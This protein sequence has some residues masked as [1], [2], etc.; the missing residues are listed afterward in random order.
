MYIWNQHEFV[1]NCLKWYKECDLEPGNP[2]DGLW[3]KAHY[4]APFCLGGEEWVWLL[5][6]HHA[7]QGVL[8]SLEF[9]HCCVGG[10]E[11]KYLVGEW[12]YLLSVFILFC[13]RR[14]RENFRNSH[15]KKDEFGRSL[16]GLKNAERMNSELDELGRSVNAVKGGILS[17]KNG[18]GALC[19]TIEQM[20]EDGKR[21]G[22]LSKERKLGI[23][24][25]GNA[26]KGGMKVCSQKWE[27]TVTGKITAAGPLTQWQRARG[28]DT[29]N[30][31]RRYD[32]EGG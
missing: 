16:L 2:E 18:K 6:E 19:R 14:A 30:R 32:L 11:K 24:A 9:D 7:I 10:W 25:P 1:E 5:K 13:G 12:E 28:I 21:G 29:S 31:I 20:T 3:H 26:R 27:C 22:T 17:R 15:Q 4:P 23:F 8:Q